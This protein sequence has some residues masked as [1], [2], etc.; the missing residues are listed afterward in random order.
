[1]LN[2]VLGKGDI[3]AE[4]EGICPTHPPQNQQG[5]EEQPHSSPERQRSKHGGLI[6]VL[7]PLV[8]SARPPGEVHF[9]SLQPQANGKSGVLS[10]NFMNVPFLE[11]EGNPGRKYLIDQSI[12]A[13]YRIPEMIRNATQE[14]LPTVVPTEPAEFEGGSI[15][16]EFAKGSD[17]V[18]HT[19]ARP[20]EDI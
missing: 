19:I 3:I 10:S 9:R 15:E 8:S 14:H 11:M 1:M 16:P 13:S 20:R 6:I 17:M 7:I 5:Q 12:L 4:I 18:G 2:S